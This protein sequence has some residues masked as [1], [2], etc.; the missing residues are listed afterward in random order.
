MFTLVHI[1]LKQKYLTYC[2]ISPA[3]LSRE[4]CTETFI[5]R[6]LGNMKSLLV[7]LGCYTLLLLV[8]NVGSDSCRGE[9]SQ[10]GFALFHKNYSSSFR[11]RFSECLDL[12]I[13]DPSC[14]SLNFWLDSKQCDLNNQSRETCPLC[15][16]AASCRYMGMARIGKSNKNTKG[17][18]SCRLSSELAFRQV[19]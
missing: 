10:N 15:Y 13:D 16:K 2:I 7:L 8:V 6:K 14:M 5:F 1:I 11:E 19:I 12:C 4:N 3:L 17:S 18:Q 9:R